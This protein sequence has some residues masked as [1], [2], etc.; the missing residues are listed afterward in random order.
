MRKGVLTRE[1]LIL[2]I[3]VITLATFLIVIIFMNQRGVDILAEIAKIFTFQ[4]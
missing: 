2:L 1:A 4:F 3:A